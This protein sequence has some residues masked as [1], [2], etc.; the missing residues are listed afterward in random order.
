[1]AAIFLFNDLQNATRS[2]ICNSFDSGSELWIKPFST[3][4]LECAARYFFLKWVPELHTHAVSRER[5]YASFL[6]RR[7]TLLVS[8]GLQLY[9]DSLYPGIEPM[10]VGLRLKG[11]QTW[12]SR[13]RVPA[14]VYIFPLRGYSRLEGG[15]PLFSLGT[16][17]KKLRNFHR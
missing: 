17:H 14:H 5:G 4:P 6:V 13:G 3:D 16:T 9:R 12:H 10:D 2:H 7:G 1:M 11:P 8:Q 15:D